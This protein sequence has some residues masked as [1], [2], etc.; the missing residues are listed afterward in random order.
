MVIQKGHTNCIVLRR[1]LRSNTVGQN[2]QRTSFPNRAEGSEQSLQRP[3]KDQWMTWSQLTNWE[4]WEAIMKASEEGLYN[5]SSEY[6]VPW[7]L[8]FLGHI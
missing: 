1:R 5:F 8:R 4:Q 2:E 3:W 6:R 7:A